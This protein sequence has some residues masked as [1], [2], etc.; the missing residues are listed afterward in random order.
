MIHQGTRLCSM[1]VKDVGGWSAPGDRVM[2]QIEV[3]GSDLQ[4]LQAFLGW[5][6]AHEGTCQ[7]A[8]IIP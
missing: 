8:R 1:A 2:I 6:H 7:T 4:P 3:G 5:G